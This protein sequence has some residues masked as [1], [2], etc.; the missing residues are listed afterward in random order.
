MSSSHVQNGTGGTTQRYA[1]ATTCTATGNARGMWRDQTALITLN[2]AVAVG[3]TA[4]VDEHAATIASAVATAV[5]DIVIRVRI[6]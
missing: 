1:R 4:S 6:C 5:I 2:V 3:C